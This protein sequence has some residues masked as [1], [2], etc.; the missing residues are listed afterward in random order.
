MSRA[1]GPKDPPTAVVS[2]DMLRRDITALEQ[3]LQSL[4][5][6]SLP[7]DDEVNAVERDL[8]AR[9]RL[10]AAVG[11]NSGRANARRQS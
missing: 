6:E 8:A 1:L 7:M 10:L 2:A 5:A 11:Q 4:R 9:R 3:R